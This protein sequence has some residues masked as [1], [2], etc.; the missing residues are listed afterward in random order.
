MGISSFL[1]AISLLGFVLFLVGVGMIVVA[2]SQGREGNRGRGGVA[3]AIIGVI[4]GLLFSVISQGVIVVEATQV[5]VVFNT[6]NGN[7]EPPRRSGTN[8]IVPIV[9][10]AFIY[11]ISQQ[12]FSMSDR[13]TNNE[14]VDDAAVVARSQD[15]QEIRVDVS[16]LFGIDPSGNNPNI[17]HQRWQNRYRNDFIQPTVRGLVRDAFSGYRASDI[18]G[19]ARDAI[20]NNIT[21]ELQTRM[22]EEGLILTDFVLRNITFSD[23]FSSS[24]ERAQIAQQE[25]EQARLRVQQRQQEA[26]Q[27]RVV[28]QGERDAAIARAEGEAQSIILRAQAEAEALRLVS[29]QLA[30][31]PLLIQYQY[32]QT[33][34]PNVS[35]AII[36]SNSPFLFDLES[37]T[38]NTDFTA[39]AVPESNLVLPTPT[40]LASS[41][42]QP[43]S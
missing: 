31:N 17:V 30:A 27:A 43:G 15:G 1:G 28:A 23:E 7:L 35:L 36:P 33:L 26:E 19:G 12:Q 38:A 8:I 37:F 6:L 2:S 42:P 3:L 29:E 5:A 22:S 16:V 25:A 4:I 32:I 13:T 11:D 14:R 24:I 40:P 20:A 39:P 9:Q 34:G 10:Q 18:Y 21:G 41:T